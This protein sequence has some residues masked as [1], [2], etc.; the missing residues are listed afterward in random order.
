MGAHCPVKLII[1]GVRN[2][3]KNREKKIH[4]SEHREG[5]L[6]PAWERK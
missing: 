6:D 3:G 1:R 2:N 4:E 5:S